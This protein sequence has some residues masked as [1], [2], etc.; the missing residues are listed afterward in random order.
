[1][2]GS[3]QNPPMVIVTETD[4]ITITPTLPAAILTS[5]PCSTSTDTVSFGPSVARG[6]SSTASS[7]LTDTLSTSLSPFT[8]PRP[9]VAPSPSLSHLG[10]TV[11]NPL[12]TGISEIPPVFAKPNPPPPS[13]SDGGNGTN[14]AAP[15]AKYDKVFAA[16]TISAIAVMALLL[17][18]LIWYMCY[19]RAKG[20][21]QTCR[22][23]EDKL[24]KWERGE[25]KVITKNMVRERE[26]ANA[27][28][29]KGEASGGNGK[30]K[31]REEVYVP[32]WERVHNQVEITSGQMKVTAEDLKRRMKVTAQNVKDKVKGEKAKPE[33]PKIVH[34]GPQQPTVQLFTDHRQSASRESDRFFQ[35]DT[36]GMR[37]SD[38]P[39]QLQYE[40]VS[41][42]IY[43]QADTEP[44][45]FGDLS[46]FELPP[47]AKPQPM[48]A[49]KPYRYGA[50]GDG[51][52]EQAEASLLSARYKAAERDMQR[53]SAT[54]AEPQRAVE[55]VNAADQKVRRT[56]NPSI[57]TEVDL[58]GGQGG[59]AE[60]EEKDI[61]ESYQMPEWRK[62]DRARKGNIV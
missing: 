55:V 52:V 35:I 23:N 40:P 44:R 43:S 53:Q 30:D 7:I 45:I 50:A 39:P 49:K 33:P 58:R 51:H 27:D 57:F 22:E 54:E 60:V 46:T 24:E 3:M 34:L 5:V 41:P 13:H 20:K 32:F 28:L 6:S 62:R 21:C 10:I 56:R 38:S 17:F 12:V 18:S 26:S 37:P 36:E 9:I 42:S 11:T 8:F 2:A 15:D 14:P 59:A 19:L 29:E 25:L 4:Y 47:P 31:K 1:M 16:A 61:T 48:N